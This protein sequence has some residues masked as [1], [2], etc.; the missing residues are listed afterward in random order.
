MNVCIDCG[1]MFPTGLVCPGCHSTSVVNAR[2]GEPPRFKSDPAP[3]SRVTDPSTSKGR[4]PVRNSREWE[5]F[6]EW[7]KPAKGMWPTDSSLAQTAEMILGT[8]QERNVWARRRLDW[9]NEKILRRRMREDGSLVTQR[10]PRTNASEMTFALT[11]V[12]ARLLRQ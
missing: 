9:E 6:T 2:Q 3:V 10:S 1:S 7:I 12:G 4:A 8:R 5:I 11:D